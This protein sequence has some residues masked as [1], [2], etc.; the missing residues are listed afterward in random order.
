MAHKV[1]LSFSGDYFIT[2]EQEMTTNAEVSITD[3]YTT[4]MLHEDTIPGIYYTDTSVYGKLGK[5]THFI[6]SLK[7]TGNTLPQIICIHV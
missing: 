2:A 6:S 3:G 1:S 4:F 7:T 5:L